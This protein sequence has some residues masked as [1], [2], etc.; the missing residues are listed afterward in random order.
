MFITK[1]ICA[2]CKTT[3]KQELILLKKNTRIVC[4]ICK[5]PVVEIEK[6]KGYFIVIS[7][8][9]GLVQIIHSTVDSK[10]AVKE[11]NQKY[12]RKSKF[13][14]EAIFVSKNYINEQSKIEKNRKLNKFK[15]LTQDSFYKIMVHEAILILATILKIKPEWVYNKNYMT[16]F[17]TGIDL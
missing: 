1:F 15:A 13:K 4:T 17:L 3:N 12:K 6:V 11:F 8:N 5:A 9:V 2:N 10:T 16:P 7:N 14:I